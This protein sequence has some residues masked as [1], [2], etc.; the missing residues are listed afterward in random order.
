MDVMNKFLW[1]DFVIFKEAI[2]I[3]AVIHRLRIIRV[4]DILS[5]KNRLEV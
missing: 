5:I 4:K 3:K 1:F 2:I